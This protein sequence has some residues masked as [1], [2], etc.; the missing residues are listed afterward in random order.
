MLKDRPN[1]ISGASFLEK[2]KIYQSLF[3]FIEN[4]LHLFPSY[5]KDVD[6]TITNEDQITQQLSLFLDEKTRQIEYVPFQFINQFKYP[7][8][9]RSSDIGIFVKK[10][11]KKDAFFV[12]EAKRLPTIGS[13]REKEYVSGIKGGMERFKQGYHGKGLEYSSMVGYI[14]KDDCPFWETKINTWINDLIINPVVGSSLKWEANDKLVR[15]TIK[16]ANKYVSTHH[17]LN[18]VTIKLTHYWIKLN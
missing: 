16:N 3:V 2:E 13:G 8:S 6:D 11:S 14:Q 18:D 7:N 10:F 17:R 5:L 1:I 15:V 9:K 12:F 4:H